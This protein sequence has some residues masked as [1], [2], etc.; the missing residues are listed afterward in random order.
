MQRVIEIEEGRS[1]N[2]KASAFTPIQYNTLFPGSDFW[3]DLTALQGAMTNGLETFTTEDYMLLMRIS[4]TM[5]YQGLAPS[6]KQTEEQKAFL[7]EY[8]N[9][10][11]F[12]DTFEMLSLIGCLN[13]IMDLWGLS[14]V[15]EADE[16]NL[17]SPQPER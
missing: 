15:S 9:L 2:F 12:S 13:D 10:E 3:K 14:S 11:Y 16:K 6:P 8:P 1:F 17:E 4:Y 5:I 7:E